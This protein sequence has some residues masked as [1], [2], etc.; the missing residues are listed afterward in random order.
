M[1]YRLRKFKT[2]YGIK[3]GRSYLAIHIGK[4]SWYIPYHQRGKFFSINEWHGMTEVVKKA[5]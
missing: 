4:R 5:K 1:I 2:R 3:A